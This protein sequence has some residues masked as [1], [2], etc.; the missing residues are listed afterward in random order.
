MVKK[1]EKISKNAKLQ[2]KQEDPKDGEEESS[3]VQPCDTAFTT[4]VRGFG[5]YK[6]DEAE[7]VDVLTARRGALR[8]CKE[9]AKIECVLTDKCK[10]VKF[11]RIVNDCGNYVSG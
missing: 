7:L 1:P 9:L 5:E 11:I 4:T 3:P 6:G 2:Q 8:R 10:D